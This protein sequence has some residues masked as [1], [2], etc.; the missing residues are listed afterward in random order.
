MI[1]GVAAFIIAGILNIS[2]KGVATF[3]IAGDVLVIIKAIAF[4]IDGG[5]SKVEHVDVLVFLIKIVCIIIRCK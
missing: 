1:A 5:A 4:P 3:W 2:V